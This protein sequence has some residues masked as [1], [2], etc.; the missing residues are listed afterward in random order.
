MWLISA[1]AV[2]HTHS[3]HFKTNLEIFGMFVLQI[4]TYDWLNATV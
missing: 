2:R 1:D 4:M 3:L